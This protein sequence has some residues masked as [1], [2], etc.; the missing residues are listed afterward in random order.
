MYAGWQE[1][2]NYMDWPIYDSCMEG[3]GY[4]PRFRPWFANS[5]TGP[6]DIILMIDTSGSMGSDNRIGLAVQAGKSVLRTLTEH[7]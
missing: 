1:T 4:D 5:A 2:G 3:S 6:K 7:D